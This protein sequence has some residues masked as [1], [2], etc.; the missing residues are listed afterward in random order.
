MEIFTDQL[1]G[2]SFTWYL[3]KKDQ[4]DSVIEAARRGPLNETQASLIDTLEENPAPLDEAQCATFNQITWT[5]VNCT[6]LNGVLIP[7]H[8]ADEFAFASFK[9]VM[10]GEATESSRAWVETELSSDQNGTPSIGNASDPLANDFLKGLRFLLALI[11]GSIV[12]DR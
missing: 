1:E 3:G 4:L 9:D 12:F 2:R 7:N 11:K 10:D 8:L 6:Y 5:G